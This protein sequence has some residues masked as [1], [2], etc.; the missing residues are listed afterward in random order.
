MRSRSDSP[1]G[2]SSDHRRSTDRRRRAWKNES[3]DFGSGTSF[4]M[5]LLR[6][7]E[8]LIHRP[9]CP[10]RAILEGFSG[11]VAPCPLSVLAGRHDNGN[12][13]YLTRA[14]VNNPN[15]SMKSER[16]DLRERGAVA[17]KGGI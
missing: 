8:P 9:F 14:A 6:A 3:Q 4:N 10:D 11:S 5:N 1:R 16:A 2:T 17:K 13:I 15:P 7:A 12:L